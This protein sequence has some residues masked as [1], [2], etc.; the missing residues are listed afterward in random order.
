M[1]GA[2]N[3]YVMIVNSTDFNGAYTDLNFTMTQAAGPDDGC[4]CKVP[5]SSEAPLGFS[6]VSL[7]SLAALAGLLGR[8]RRN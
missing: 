1:P 7:V 5:G 2:K 3:A 8:R 6:L 4:G